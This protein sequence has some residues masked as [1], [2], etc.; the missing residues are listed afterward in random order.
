MTENW[1]NASFG[2]QMNETPAIP[3]TPFSFTLQLGDESLSVS[4]T[5]PATECPVTDL[6]PLLLSLGEGIVA[7]ASRQAPGDKPISCGPGCGACCRQLVPISL[8]EVAYLRHEVLP[9]LPEDHRLRIKLRLADAATILHASGLLGELQALPAQ[10]DPARRQ[11]VGL[12]YFLGGI[13]CPFL[14]Q[15]SCSIHLQR[16]LACRE[17]LVVSP[18]PHC[19]RPDHGGIES[20][21]IPNKPS[22][23]LIQLDAAA[24]RSPGWRTMIEALTNDVVAPNRTIPDPIEFFKNFLALLLGNGSI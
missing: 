20:V 8:S 18:V 23:A 19:S 3:L 11:A 15:E 13:P 12:R 2:F 21:P 4:G 1:A 24:T 5:V 17:Y 10:T 9:N 14:E 7:A 16:P 6:I 22:H